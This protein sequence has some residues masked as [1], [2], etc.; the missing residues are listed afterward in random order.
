MYRNQ[1]MINNMGKITSCTR[2]YLTA[3]ATVLGIHVLA[4]DFI[5]NLRQNCIGNETLR[6]SKIV[7]GVLSRKWNNRR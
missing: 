3:S 2:K 5:S 1:D 4:D 7:L 6:I